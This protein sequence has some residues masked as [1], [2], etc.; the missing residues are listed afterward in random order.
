MPTSPDTQLVQLMESVRKQDELV[1]SLIG[2]LVTVEVAIVAAVGL[3]WGVATPTVGVGMKAF[4]TFV[5]GVMGIVACWVF[6]LAAKSDLWWQGEYIRYIKAIEPSL[7]KDCKVKPDEWGFQAKLYMW[8]GFAMT[9]FWLGI[10][11]AAIL[12]LWCA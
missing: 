11:V 12:Q 3:V 7:F 1:H 6:V 10:M 5:L 2:R 4:A 9:A 8:L